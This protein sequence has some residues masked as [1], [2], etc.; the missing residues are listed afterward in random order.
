MDPE[1]ERHHSLTGPPDDKRRV[2]R[3]RSHVETDFTVMETVVLLLG[4]GSQG[5]HWLGSA[6]K[7]GTD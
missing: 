1:D 2:E 4:G 5:G 7:H 3:E 6:D